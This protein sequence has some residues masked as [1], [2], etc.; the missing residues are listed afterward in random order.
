MDLLGDLWR[1]A[2]QRSGLRNGFGI[3]KTFQLVI[4]WILVGIPLAW[5]VVQSIQKS[6]P[7]L[8]G[9]TPVELKGAMKPGEK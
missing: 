6:L 7:L 3:M 9:S 4:A 1:V 5:G 2:V 8:R